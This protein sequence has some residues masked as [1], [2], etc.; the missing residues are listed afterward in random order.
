[1][2]ML[3]GENSCYNITPTREE[4]RHTRELAHNE[5][6][7]LRVQENPVYQISSTATLNL[8]TE[9][10]T[11]AEYAEVTF[12]E[13]RDMTTDTNIAYGFSRATESHDTADNYQYIEDTTQ[14]NCANTTP[15]QPETDSNYGNSNEIYQ[16]ISNREN[17]L[18]QPPTI[19][20]ILAMP[21]VTGRTRSTVC[22]F[23]QGRVE[24]CTRLATI[25]VS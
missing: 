10:R 3:V 11:A 4:I 21:T 14:Q 19:E 20:Q 2:E 1:M 23:W 7:E 8:G 17:N 25:V 16:E 18:T 12:S 24:V 22:S 9:D 13:N 6:I 5:V 15:S